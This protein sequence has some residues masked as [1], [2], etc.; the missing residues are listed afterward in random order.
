MTM[1]SMNKANINA[2]SFEFAS[3]VETND[4]Q[5]LVMLDGR[6]LIGG[7]GS[8]RIGIDPPAFFS[9]RSL[10]EGGELLIG[11]CGC[12]AIGCDDERMRVEL[13]SDSVIWWDRHGRSHVFDRIQ[14]M[15]AIAEATSSTQWESAQRRAERLVS[16]LDFSP[17]EEAGYH[18]E[19]ASAR[20]G[21]GKI[22]LSFGAGGTQRIF[23]I[24]CDHDDPDDAVRNVRRWIAEFRAH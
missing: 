11:R 6:C 16:Q 17:L 21:C 9:Q 3:S 18:F 24:G 1:G 7:A 15:Q 22:V 5:V 14:Y 2:I 12:G 23:E 4:D 13:A 10:M 8:D 19:W 20:I